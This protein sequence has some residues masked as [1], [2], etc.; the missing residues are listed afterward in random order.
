[1]EECVD[2]YDLGCK[3]FSEIESLDLIFLDNPSEYFISKFLNEDQKKQCLL[4]IADCLTESGL[5]DKAFSYYLD[6]GVSESPETV[7]KLVD[8]SKKE[9]VSYKGLKYETDKS[10]KVLLDDIIYDKYNLV[11]SKSTP[12]KIL[13]APDEFKE[14]FISVVEED[15][16]DFKEQKGWIIKNN[17]VWNLKPMIRY[18]N[19][20]DIFKNLEFTYENVRMAHAIADAYTSLGRKDEADELYSFLES[21]GFRDISFSDL[22]ERYNK[23]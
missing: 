8:A 23:P 22:L 7:Q 10:P 18:F 2:C 21:K 6:I 20:T 15:I 17:A 4:G 16:S 3:V 19:E 5:L 12:E 13:T 9:S 1:M 14:I 11:Y